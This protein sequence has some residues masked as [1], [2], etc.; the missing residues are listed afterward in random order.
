MQLP[1]V[2]LTK[3]NVNVGIHRVG[4]SNVK[5]PVYVQ[6]KSGDYQHTVADIDIFVDLEAHQKGTHMSRLVSAAQEFM[7]SKLSQHTME[8]LAEHI[9]N[10]AE[11]NVC[12]LNYKF[13]YFIQ[14]EAP[15]SGQT[16]VIH[17]NVEFN[18]VYIRNNYSIFKIQL[19]NNV[20]SLCPCSKELAEASNNGGA[21]NQKSTIKVLCETSDLVWIEDIIEATNGCGSC[22]VYS[23]LKRPDE[24]HV[25]IHAYNNPLFCEDIVRNCY[26]ELSKFENIKW[27]R[28]ESTSHESIH[29]H[30]ATAIIDT[31][32]L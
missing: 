7:N 11:A 1:D 32:Y 19:D 29:Q 2:Q 10:Y 23:I 13:P 9:V 27:F 21:H 6:Q 8:Q 17:H 22:Q 18:L 3:S 15:V 26:V 25:T 24:Q 30:Y 16:G 28:V 14:K 4:V 31:R 12:E 5:L 20:T